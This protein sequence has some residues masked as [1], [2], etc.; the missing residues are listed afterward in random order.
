MEL[1]QEMTYHLLLAPPQQIGIGPFGARLF[2]EVIGGE[3]SGAR[4]SGKVLRGGGDWAIAG[5]DGF[6]RLDVRAQFQTD[7]G[8][9]I[10]VSYYGLLELNEAVQSAFAT[11]TET[12]FEDQYFRNSPRFETGDPRYAWLQQ[13]LFVGEGRLY[14]G[15]AVEYQVYRVT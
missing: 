12:R 14:P 8:A 7:D 3:V 10:Y 13:S 4:I 6:S 2:A 9:V 15:F 1:V 5:S 11:A